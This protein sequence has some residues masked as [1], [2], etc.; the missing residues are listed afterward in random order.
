VK[1]TSEPYK[2]PS[3][4]K[5]RRRYGIPDTV[6]LWEVRYEYWLWWIKFT[7]CINSQAVR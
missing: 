5:K 4:Y 2:A 3:A 7:S 1:T 6:Q